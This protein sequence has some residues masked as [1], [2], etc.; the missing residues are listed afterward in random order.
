LPDDP[1]RDEEL[2]AL[3]G[4][5]R[6][7]LVGP[8]RRQTITAAG[9]STRDPNAAVAEY[10]T[11]YNVTLHQ[12]FTSAAE[13]CAY[14]RWRNDQYF[15]YI[16][17]MPVGAQDGKVVLDFGCGPGHDLVGFATASRPAR[18]IGID[19]SPSSIAEARER[20]SLHQ[21]ACEFIRLDPR[22]TQLPL[23]RASVDY[24]HS[25]GV[26][27]HLPD[28]SPLLR[29]FRRVLRPSGSARIMIYNHDSVWMHLFVAYMKRI[30]E[31]AHADLTLEQAFGR[32]TDGE[33]CP[34]AHVFHP[35]EFI[36]LAH[37]AGF[38]AV[39]TGAAVS[40]HEAKILPYRFD[41]I[42]D[43][44]TPEISRRFLLELTY[45]GFGM[46]WYHGHRAGL[47]ACFLLT[48]R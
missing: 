27:H 24:V 8:S 30:V 25:S 37:Q 41:A 15:G 2:M 39:F 23:A 14:V 16:D 10:W 18:L 1:D 9:K 11:R 3:G 12:N 38:D 43:R 28:A 46:P 13:S 20:L 47:D 34:I 36:A 31:K 29:E 35:A 5:L 19:V 44:R 17:L 7:L 48:P 32:T 6:S 42:Q 33:D 45:D 22:S 21:A 4:Y 26:L 40:M